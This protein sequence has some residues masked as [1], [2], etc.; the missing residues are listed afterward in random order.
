MEGESDSP[1]PVSATT[2]QDAANKPNQLQKPTSISSTAGG[3]RAKA[4]PPKK[5]PEAEVRWFDNYAP[6]KVHKVPKEYRQ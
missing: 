3:A 6:L 4:P 5:L 2:E 1:P